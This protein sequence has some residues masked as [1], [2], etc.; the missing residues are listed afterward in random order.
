M[1]SALHLD[2]VRWAS[3]R[4]DALVVSFSRFSLVHASEP[5]AR[6]GDKLGEFLVREEGDKVGW[7]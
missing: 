6:E 2:Q 3:D 4:A 5:Q 7:V 1:P